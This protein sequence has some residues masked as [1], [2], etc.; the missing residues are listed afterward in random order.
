MAETTPAEKLFSR[1]QLPA[2]WTEVN[3]AVSLSGGVDSIALLRILKALKTRHGGS[4]QLL[5]VHVN[6]HLRG[7]ESSADAHWCERSCQVLGVPVKILSA[8]TSQ[9]AH[10]TGQGLEAAAREQRYQLLTRAA[11]ESGVRYLATAH[12]RDD[13]VETILFRTLR[14]TGLR[15]LAGI[16]SSRSLTPSLTLIRPL[17]DCSRSMLIEY[18]GQLK[19][20]YRT[21]SSNDDRQFTRNRIRHDLL[22]T[23]RNEFNA[24]LD[25]ALLRLAQQASDAQSLVERLAGDLLDEADFSLAASSLSM[26]ALPFASRER[27]LVCE[28]LRLAWRRA[29]LAEQAMTFDWWCTLARMLMRTDETSSLNLPGNIHAS[30]QGDRLVISW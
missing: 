30:L 13:Q 23:L 19:Q 28:S 5:A 16:P 20:E 14:G 1:V 10:D 12:T 25:G 18:L 3:V 9:F 29:E 7:D 26:L 15:G 17:L 6:H 4:G 24:D 21:D 8:N 11:E 22:P 2:G 27:L